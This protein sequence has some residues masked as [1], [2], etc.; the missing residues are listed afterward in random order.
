MVLLCGSSL[1]RVLWVYS[2]AHDVSN[3]YSE[4]C[5]GGT[6]IAAD[7]GIVLF[8]GVATLYD[9]WGNSPINQVLDV[10]YERLMFW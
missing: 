10:Q 6:L 5:L 3:V 7:F 4:V 2:V 9:S 8:V 1:G